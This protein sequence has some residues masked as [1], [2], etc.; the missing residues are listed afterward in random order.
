MPQPVQSFENHVRHVPL[1]SV[2]GLILAVNI[3]WS[4]YRLV[5]FFSGESIVAFLLALALGIIW[6]NARR[7]PLTVQDRLIRL[8]MMLRLERVLPAD[9]RARIGEFSLSQL[10]ALRFAS[11]GELPELARKVLADNISDRTAIKRMI[12]TWNPDYLRV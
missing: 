3:L 8:E 12:R 10:L 11:E 2:A 5:R 7:F 4:L 9:L 6:A 1:N